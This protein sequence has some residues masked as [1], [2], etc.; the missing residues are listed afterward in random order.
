MSI[1]V[2]LSLLQEAEKEI[3]IDACYFVVRVLRNASRGYPDV[4]VSTEPSPEARNLAERAIREIEA[5]EKAPIPQLTE[6]R[7]GEYIESLEEFLRTTYIR[8]VGTD[9][10]GAASILEQM[11][12]SNE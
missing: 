10:A 3:L 1:E 2:P 6:D 9:I 8:A 12:S 7:L 11:R 4:A 5:R